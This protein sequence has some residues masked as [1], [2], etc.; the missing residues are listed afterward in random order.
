MNTADLDTLLVVIR[1]GSFAAAAREL[2]VDPSSVSRTISALESELGTRLFQRNTRQ[3]TMTEAGAVFVDLSATIPSAGAE[4][5]LLP[6]DGIHPNAEGH[7]R[8]AAAIRS[9]I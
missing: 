1:L 8:I 9:A 2:H 5:L 6:Y 3:L 7:R 4:N